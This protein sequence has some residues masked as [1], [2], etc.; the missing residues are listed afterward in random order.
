MIF[1]AFYLNEDTFFIP[2]DDFWW[3]CSKGRYIVYS[4]RWYL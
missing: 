3:F 1:Y 4:F 2:L